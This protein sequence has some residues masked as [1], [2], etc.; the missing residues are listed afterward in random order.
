VCHSQEGP[1]W[2]TS[3]AT[4]A[5]AAAI[6]IISWESFIAQSRDEEKVLAFMRLA[7]ESI[8]TKEKTNHSSSSSKGGSSANIKNCLIAKS[9]RIYD[10]NAA[11]NVCTM[12]VVE[13]VED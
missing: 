5:A 13:W 7:F 1:S 4:A 10:K 11:F 12:V 8:K 6:L 3:W 2:F 9:K